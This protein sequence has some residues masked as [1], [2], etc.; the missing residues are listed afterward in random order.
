MLDHNFVK[1]QL[2]INCLYS[3]TFELQLGYFASKMLE[4]FI[5][6]LPTKFY[7]TNKTVCLQAI[8]L[9]L[10]KK[11]RKKHELVFFCFVFDF[12]RKAFQCWNTLQNNIILHLF[13]FS[14]GWKRF[15]YIKIKRYP[16]K[17]LNNFWYWQV[18]LTTEVE[19][20]DLKKT[21]KPDAK[22]VVGSNRVPFRLF[23]I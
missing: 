19:I 18:Q 14:Q 7:D 12:Q 6:F 4:W 11:E 15:Q 16:W 17:P 8:F 5:Y 13:S 3:I 22:T 21:C 20:W 10:V 1:V 2:C 9:S 23:S